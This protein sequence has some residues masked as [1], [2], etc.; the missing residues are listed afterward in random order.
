MLFLRGYIYR[1]VK[2]NVQTSN[3][4]LVSRKQIGDVLWS[5]SELPKNM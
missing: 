3:K 2:L 4:E 5:I 1:G